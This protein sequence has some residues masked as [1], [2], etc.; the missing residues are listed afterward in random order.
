M[1]EP[2]EQDLARWDKWDDLRARKAAATSDAERITLAVEEEELRQKG[3]EECMENDLDSDSRWL[4][5]SF[6]NVQTNKNLGVAIVKAGGII[7]ATQQAHTMGFNPGG[8]VLAY[9]LD[10]DNLPDEKYRYRLLQQEELR[11]AGL[12]D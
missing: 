10:P 8:E 7:E 4:W 12:A 6:R 9:V 11:E 2:T 5:L 3:I 1:S